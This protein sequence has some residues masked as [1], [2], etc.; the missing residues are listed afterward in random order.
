MNISDGVSPDMRYL[1]PAYLP[2]GIISIWVLSKT[3][4]LKR[5]KEL[6]MFGLIGTVI[7]APLLFILSM[8]GN[9]FVSLNPGY[10]KFFDFTILCG[11]MLCLG[12]MFIYRF[13]LNESPF[14][15]QVIPYILVLLIITVFTLQLVLVFIFGEIVKFN[16]YPLWI[17][18]IEKGFSTFFHVSILPSG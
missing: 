17:P 5:P 15:P 18:F 6:V 12:L 14:L 13:C 4:F 7:I 9:P 16:G 11:I 8:A 2:C 10:F 3:P 1:S